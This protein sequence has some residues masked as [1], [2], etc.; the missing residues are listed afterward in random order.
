M[1]YAQ[2]FQK[3]IQ[4]CETEIAGYREKILELQKKVKSNENIIAMQSKS[5]LLPDEKKQVGI[6]KVQNNIKL[7]TEQIGAFQDQIVECSEE[8]T[9]YITDGLACLPD[10][11]TPKEEQ[12]E[13][14]K[15]IIKKKPDLFHKMGLIREK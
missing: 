13:T 10:T 9:E 8:I 7:L 15:P 14:P 11:E 1:T 6:E 12:T 5:T 2:W 3:S 4:G